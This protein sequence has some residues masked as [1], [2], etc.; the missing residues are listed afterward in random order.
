MEGSSMRTNSISKPQSI[1]LVLPLI[2]VCAVAGSGDAGAAG[3]ADSPQ[4]PP[5]PKVVGP[6]GIPGT[7]DDGW[8][9]EDF[10]T[11][12]D[13]TPGISLDSMPRGTPGVLNDT[14]GVWVGTAPGGIGTLAGIG[15]AGF[16]VP[17]ADP[18]CRIDPDNDMDWHIH[19]PAGSCPNRPGLVTPEGGDFSFS[20]RNSL[21]WGH[22]FDPH[23]R[24]GDSTKFRQ[25]AAFMTDP[26]HLTPV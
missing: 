9:F 2:I 20:G 3:P 14:I 23:S 15:C 5:P 16:I 12:R 25:L 24:D 6:D 8:I 1:R 21:H 13:G 18:E 10:D 4:C 11:E 22:H 19:C 7:A 26:V 17:P